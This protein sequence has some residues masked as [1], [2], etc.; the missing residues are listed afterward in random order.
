MPAPRAPSAAD[1]PTFVDKVLGFG[2]YLARFPVLLTIIAV[3][4]D[5]LS[6]IPV[7]HKGMMTLLGTMH[8]LEPG[9]GF[10]VPYIGTLE[11]INVG[12]DTD[13]TEHV[14]CISRDYVD[15]KFDKVYV[16]NQFSCNNNITCYKKLMTDYFISDSKTKAK[17]PKMLVPEDGII[18]KHLPEAMAKACK[19]MK[20]HTMLTRWHEMYPIIIDELRAKV[21]PGIDIIAVRTERPDF[22]GIPWRTSI[23]G[24]ISSNVYVVLTGR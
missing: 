24:I 9:I 16:D 5:S 4:L 8:V 17:H 15:I 11:N 23:R 12:F 10:N 13:F 22:K 3:I 19:T 20:A 7:K 21:P 6:I 14:K 1:K 2:M 18:F